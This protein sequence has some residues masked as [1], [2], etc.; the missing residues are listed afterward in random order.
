MSNSTTAN[1]LGLSND[2][3]FQQTINLA[4]HTIDYA[5]G[6][7]GFGKSKVVDSA[8]DVAESK[9]GQQGSHSLY[10]LFN[11]S[12]DLAASILGTV[13]EFI[14][15]KADQAKDLASDATST[16][17]DV[18]DS[19]QGT[20]RDAKDSVKDT[21]RDAKDSAKDTARD[22]KDR[23]AQSSGGQKSLG[24]VAS[25]RNLAG[26]VIG[27]VQGI[28][29][30]GARKVDEAT[31]DSA[32]EAKDLA[33]DKASQ[34]KQYAENKKEDAK[35]TLANAQETIRGYAQQ[36]VNQAANVVMDQADQYAKETKNTARAAKA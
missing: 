33:S 27:Q 14:E 29:A 19:A 10:D 4:S 3:L 32:Q 9:Q 24:Y 28:V 31:P 18:K 34:G 20:A 25:V 26:S 35:G 15:V 23:V 13:Q 22:A 30:S 16:A 21:A 11:E 36:G 12:R 5:L 8:R 7:V 6:V 2:S 1:K 17:R